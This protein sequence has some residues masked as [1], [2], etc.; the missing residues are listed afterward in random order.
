MPICCLWLSDALNEID[1]IFC[2]YAEEIKTKV[3]PPFD[4][5]GTRGN[6]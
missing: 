1:F 3:R 5:Q 6:K 2:A 4:G